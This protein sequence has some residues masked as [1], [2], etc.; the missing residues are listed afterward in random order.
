M[1]VPAVCSEAVVSSSISDFW[2]KMTADEIGQCVENGKERGAAPFLFTQKSM[3]NLLVV[4][5]RK[6]DLVSRTK[7]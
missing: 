1:N 7:S 2:F 4:E 3:T 6:T 5:L